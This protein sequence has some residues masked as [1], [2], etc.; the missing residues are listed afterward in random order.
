MYAS[1]DLSLRV[2]RSVPP[3]SRGRYAFLE[4]FL[5][6]V[7]IFAILREIA[8]GLIW[9]SKT[10]FGWQV[11]SV[12]EG[13]A[14]TI[15]I[16]GGLILSVLLSTA[17]DRAKADRD[18]NG[19]S[20]T[21]FRLLAHGVSGV[22]GGK[23]ILRILAA[24]AWTIYYF[25]RREDV[26]VLLDGRKL[27]GFCPLVHVLLDQIDELPIN[28]ERKLEWQTQTRLMLGALGG[29]VSR[30][31]YRILRS[32]YVNNVLFTSLGILLMI[33]S[34]LTGSGNWWVGQVI[35]FFFTYGATSIFFVT[36]HLAD[37]IGYDPGDIRPDL[38]LETWL[39]EIEAACMNGGIDLVEI[40]EPTER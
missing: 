30:R 39:G 22:E 27:R 34:V 13:Y 28:S 16:V 21:T 8:S 26:E 14:A 17:S 37:G 38:S 7:L 25:Y 11:V 12:N 1:V 31:T 10:Y 33:L 36:V 29:I 9:A 40:F 20:T 19:E 35:L 2:P 23:K 18:A 5:P 32:R 4:A 15:M 3:P 24:L 6:A